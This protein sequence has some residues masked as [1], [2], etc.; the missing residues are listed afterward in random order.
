MKN[1]YNMEQKEYNSNKSAYAAERRTKK[2]PMKW[3]LLL[4]AMLLLPTFAMAQEKMTNENANEVYVKFGYVKATKTYPEGNQ[5]TYVNVSGLPKDRSVVDEMRK[6]LLM[7]MRINRVNIYSDQDRFVLDADADVNPEHVV[8]EMNIFL[9]KYY[10]E[11]EKIRE[12][13]KDKR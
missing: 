3:L 6:H 11:Q 4:A 2:S 13:N 7:N 10:A 1:N 8:D 9:R 5:I 12:H